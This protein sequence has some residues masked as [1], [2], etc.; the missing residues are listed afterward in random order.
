MDPMPQ[1]SGS[2]PNTWMTDRNY[3]SIPPRRY[4]IINTCHTENG[5]PYT[6]E[7]LFFSKK[8]YMLPNEAKR[9]IDAA[10]GLLKLKKY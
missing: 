7:N 2:D 3:T 1:P 5:V 10:L 4:G 6:N 8:V 9:R